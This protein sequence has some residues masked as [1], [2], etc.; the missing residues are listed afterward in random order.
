M[1]FN[2][3]LYIKGMKCM[4]CDLMNLLKKELM[5]S[6]YLK[7]AFRIELSLLPFAGASILALI[8][9]VA[10]TIT[11]ALKAAYT[12]PAETLRDE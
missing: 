11:Q 2:N 10:T 7:S 1:F 5:F 3:H 8:I 6:N 12:N 4:A 9:A